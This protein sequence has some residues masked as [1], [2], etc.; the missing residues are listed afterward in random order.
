MIS[1]NPYQVYRQTQIKTVSQGKLILMLYEGALGF[2]NQALKAISEKN[3]EQ[4]NYYLI[5]TQN[6]ID[7]L[8]NTLNMAVGGETARHLYTFYQSINKLLIEA[9]M[10]SDC[11]PVEEAIKMLKEMHQAWQII[12]CGSSPTVEEETSA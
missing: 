5:R 4:I 7:E 6:I 2:L 9:N 12:I 10:Q 3:F 11:R 8:A 1:S